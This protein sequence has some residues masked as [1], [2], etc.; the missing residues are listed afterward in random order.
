MKIVI[1]MKSPNAIWNAVHEAARTAA[2]P[3][4]SIADL[5]ERRED[6]C[7]VLDKFVENR[8]RLNIE[9]DL[10]AETVRVISNEEWAIYGQELL[11]VDVSPVR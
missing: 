2:V 6:I 1:T 11:D 8:D 7:R 4:E 5:E 3:G 9:F 10:V